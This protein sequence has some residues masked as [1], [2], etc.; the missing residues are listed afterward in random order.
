MR[1]SYPDRRA[2]GSSGSGALKRRVFLERALGVAVAAPVL[3]SVGSLQAGEPERAA[4]GAR[5]IKLGVVGCGGRGAWIAKLFQNHGGYVLWAVADYFATVSDSAGTALGVDPSR[6]FSGLGGCRRLL[7]S[8]VEAVALETPPYW[9]PDYASASVDAGKH[10][11]MAKPVAVDVPGCRRI[12]AAAGR[13][14]AA[15]RCFF[16]DYQMPTDPHN[17]E[18][19]R[20]LGAGQIGPVQTVNSHY[21][22]GQFADPPKTSTIE[23]RLRSLIWCNDVAVGGGYHVNACIHAVDAALW[24]AGARPVSATGFSRLGRPDPHGDSHDVFSLLFEFGDGLIVSHRGKHLN[25]GT[26]FDVSVEVQGQAGHARLGYG[27]KASLRSGDDGYTGEV[28]NLYEAGAVRNIA[29]FHRLVLAGDCSNTT[30]A[31]SLDGALTTILGREA[32]LR[33]ARLTLEELVRENR[34]LEVDLRG[35]KE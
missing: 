26:D 15:R 10:V 18:V 11:Y 22:A 21:Y 35:L 29:A 32:G 3:R 5:R 30:V 2:G 6:R 27:G 31:R 7:E 4:A 24:V 33:R 20:R 19:M 25:N 12:E 14:A 23:S 17:I 8:G 13:A 34:R 28:Q 16:V 9:F 1:R